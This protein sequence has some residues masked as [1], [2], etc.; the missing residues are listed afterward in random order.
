MDW[1]TRLKVIK[2]V[3]RGLAELYKELP[4]L[5][6]PHGHLKSSN[7]LLNGACEPVLSDYGLI[8]LI[9]Q[10]SAHEHMVAY[11]SPEYFNN[12]RVTKKTDVWALGILIMETLTGKIPASYFQEGNQEVDMSG[13]VKSVVEQG[14]DKSM[15][16]T[17]NSEGEMQKLLNIG[18]LCCESDVEK[19]VDIKEACE[20]ID[21]IKERDNDDDF[22]SVTEGDLRSSRG[23]SEDFTVNI[24]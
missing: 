7:V 12:G 3:A 5:V 22:Y 1:P 21:E 19:R 10:E 16:L 11:K 24:N 4:C 2:G 6:A 20:R 17:N 9:N 18:M 15:G 8:P 14:F 13:W 23:L